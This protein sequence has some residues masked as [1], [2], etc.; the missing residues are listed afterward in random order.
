MNKQL[1]MFPSGLSHE[2]YDRL[3]SLID[4][5]SGLAVDELL[6]SARQH[7]VLTQK[8]HAQN[9]IVNLRLATAIV[10]VI[11][12]V[13]KDWDTLPAN[14][15]N[16]LSGAFCYFFHSDDDEPDFSSPIG[17]ED[18][19]EV[20]NACLRFARLDDLCLNVDDYDDA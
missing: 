4:Q 14:V 1:G 2:Q 10:E 6:V 15:Q 16:W 19:A 5:V 18:D 9:A 11:E 3:A 17:F 12:Q 7:L 20:L 8:V 13:I